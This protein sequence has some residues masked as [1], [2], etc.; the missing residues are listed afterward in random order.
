VAVALNLGNNTT[1]NANGGTLAL[2]APVNSV[3][4]SAVTANV[5]IGATLSLGGAGNAL[6]N[7]AGTHVNVTNNGTLA[8]T[9]AGKR[10]GNIT[11]TGTTSVTTAGATLTANHIRQS[12]LNIGAGN[13]VTVAANGTNT[14]TSKLTTL[15]INATGKLDLNDNDLIVD[16]GNLATLTALLASGLDINGSYGNG[17]G[18]TSSAFAT[19][20]DFNTVLGIAANVEL[21]YMSFSGQTVDANDVLIKYTYYGD[22]DLNGLVDTSTDFDLYITG[23]TSGGSLGGWLFGD[24][25]YNGSVDSATDF[26][27]YITGLSTQGSPLLTAGGNLVQAVPEPSTL[28]LGGITLLGFAGAGLRRRRT[29]T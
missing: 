24:F 10:V 7:G 25:D 20:I 5:G 14:G 28:V 12:M 21:G 3:L 22:A 17:P 9:T 19:N 27:L 23:L 2:N 8:A 15:S 1:I 4:G 11:G 29:L 18:I 26:D 13:S 16:N 6:S